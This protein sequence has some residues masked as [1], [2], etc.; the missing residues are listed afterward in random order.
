MQHRRSV[1]FDGFRIVLSAKDEALAAALAGLKTQGA[2][3]L[4][5]M[6][7]RLG[8]HVPDVNE[9]IRE[10]IEGTGTAGLSARGSPAR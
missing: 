6:R 10:R 7:S 1:R 5:P 4:V 8:L 3:Q 2:G 9:W